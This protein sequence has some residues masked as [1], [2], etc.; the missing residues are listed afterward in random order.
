V[1]R[2]QAPG[3]GALLCFGIARALAAD[4]V[5]ELNEAERMLPTLRAPEPPT[6]CPLC[7]CPVSGA[8]KDENGD[9]TWHCAYGCNP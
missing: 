8:E 1:N 3:F 7:S 2:P 6:S 9:W 4:D 5:P